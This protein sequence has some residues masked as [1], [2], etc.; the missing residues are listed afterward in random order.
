MFEVQMLI[1]VAANDGTTF[2][3]AHHTVFEAEILTAF[4]GYTLLLAG[5]VGG[6]RN[7]DGVTYADATRLYVIAVGSIVDGAK[8][9]TLAAFAKAHYAQEAIA[10][11]YLGIFEIL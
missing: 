6:W 4:G 7:T 3:A 8:V 2:S 5:A 1:P 11:R 9:G 10:I